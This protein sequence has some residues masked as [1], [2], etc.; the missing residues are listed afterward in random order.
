MKAC[1]KKRKEACLAPINT[2]ILTAAPFHCLALSLARAKD[3]AGAEKAFQAG[4]NESGRIDDLKLDYARLL[5]AQQRAVD[6]LHLLNG[7]VSANPKHSG[8]WRLGAEIATSQPD[9]LEF[10][11]DWTGEALKALPSDAVLLAA[12]AEVLLLTQKTAD[13]LPLWATLVSQER[14]PRALAAAI[15]CASVEAAVAGRPAND[16]EENTTSR[17]FVEWYRRLVNFGANEIINRLNGRVEAVRAVLPS[18]AGVLD[19]VLA[20]TG[21][22]E[23]RAVA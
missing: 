7:I 18:A 9:F 3:F 15:I 5:V 23:E 19:V 2:D 4:M 10:A 22:S 17:A 20:E 11:V 13:A 6:A 16:A 8:A 12:R 21:E 1:V 14:T